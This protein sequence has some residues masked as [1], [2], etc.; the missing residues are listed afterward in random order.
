MEKKTPKIKILLAI[1]LLI[2]GLFVFRHGTGSLNAAQK[3]AG[4]F[5]FILQEFASK[6]VIGII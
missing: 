6:D 2:I 5:L 4:N 3:A 1:I